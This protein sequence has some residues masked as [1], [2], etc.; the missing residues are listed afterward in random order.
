[1]KYKKQDTIGNLESIELNDNK[2]EENNNEFINEKRNSLNNNEKDG[3]IEF[4]EKIGIRDSTSKEYKILNSKDNNSI[5][6]NFDDFG[7]ENQNENFTIAEIA[8]KNAKDLV[9]ELFA[10]SFS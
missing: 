1:M 2:I 4:Y 3:I 8:N 5:D 10:T 9:D 7:N 6:R